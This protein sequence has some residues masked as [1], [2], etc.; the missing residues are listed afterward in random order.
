MD[1]IETMVFN[2]E[3]TNRSDFRHIQ[4]STE[5]IDEVKPSKGPKHSKIRELQKA[6]EREEGSQASVKKTKKLDRELERAR[7]ARPRLVI[8]PAVS[9]DD[10]EDPRVRRILIEDVYKS[11]A[12]RSYDQP[13][14]SIARG[15][16]PSGYT[17]NDPLS[18][19]KLAPPY[20]APEWRSDCVQWD[21]RQLRAHCDSTKV[22]W[23]SHHRR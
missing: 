22:F 8:A 15:P 12:Q 3:T 1:H 16:L 13:T 7:R 19:P 9:I 2:Y 5:I 17:R 23:R 21:R 20:V 14:S 18:L 11:N 6:S 4:Q 10:I